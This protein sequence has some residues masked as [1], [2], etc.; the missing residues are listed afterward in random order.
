MQST[1]WKR[2]REWLK[3]CPRAAGRGSGR[4]PD[5]G[6]VQRAPSGASGPRIQSASSWWASRARGRAESSR[7]QELARCSA[8]P[9]STRLGSSPGPWRPPQHPESCPTH[10][11]TAPTRPGRGAC[12][13]L[14]WRLPEMPG[15]L[16][17]LL[18]RPVD[19]PTASKL[20]IEPLAEVSVAGPAGAGRPGGYRGLAPGGITD[21]PGSPWLM[22]RA[23]L[24]QTNQ[25][26]KKPA[27]AGPG[28][29]G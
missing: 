9:R 3:R 12:A 11:G 29:R 27:L 21:E 20:E 7:K 24:K 15:A 10:H 1:A 19:L 23:Q 22:D 14:V 8:G 2:A 17:L 4:S 18:G 6:W 28:G 5:S 16:E 26:N 25:Q 13:A